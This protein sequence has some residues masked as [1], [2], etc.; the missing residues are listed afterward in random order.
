MRVRHAAVV[1]RETASLLL[2]LLGAGLVGA[3]AV[4]AWVWYAAGSPEW[5]EVL[6]TFGGL[7]L[8]VGVL[9]TVLRLVPWLRDVDQ[10]WRSAGRTGR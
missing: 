9:G 3:G 2:L 7:G 6:L 10:R 5:F 4:V 8:L 1:L